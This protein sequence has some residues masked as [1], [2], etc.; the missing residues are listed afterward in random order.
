MLQNR[1]GH[2]PLRESFSTGPFPP[3]PHLPTPLLQ[4]FPS[5]VTCLVC[6]APK[7]EGASFVCVN[8]FFFYCLGFLLCLFPPTYKHVLSPGFLPFSSLSPNPSYHL[9]GSSPASCCPRLSLLFRQKRP[10]STR[11]GTLLTTMRFMETQQSEGK[12]WSIGTR[13]CRQPSQ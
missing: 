7:A 8:L 3:F 4:P 10:R 5:T 13:N 11:A 6:G 2:G 1:T 12:S 9:S